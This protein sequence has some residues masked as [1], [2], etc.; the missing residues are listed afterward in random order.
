[1]KRSQVYWLCQVLGW[2]SHAAANVAF[3]VGYGTSPWRLIAIYTWGACAAIACTHG[4]RAWIRRT[5]WLRL[6]PL[7]VL[8]RVFFASLLIGCAITILIASLWPIVFSWK[9]LLDGHWSWVFPAIFVWSITA[10]LWAV[11]YF[12]VHYFESYE[13]SE[14]EKLRLA[15]VA[16]DAELRVLLSQVNPHFIFN[17]LNS[18]RALILEDAPRAQ[19]MV[20]EL[21]NML[22]YSLQSGRTE[23]VSLET[24]L[25]AVSAYLKLEAIRLEERLR[26]RID[27]DPTSLET[28]IPPMLLQTLV[29][30]G[31]KHGI[32]RLP[33]GG[34]IRVASHMR[35]GALRIEVRN[36]GQLAE[37][38]GTTRVGLENIRQRLRLL[39]G[40]AAS[41]V[42]RN[43]DA[44]FVV[45]EVSIPAVRANA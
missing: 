29:E 35:N 27:M 13:T 36:S 45:A 28:P 19:S 34:E 40:D 14:V 15:V 31:V 10:F 6:S 42:L 20:T 17:C 37:T 9:A 38:A 8:P 7:R 24:E 25:E 43:L 11:I 12:G 2:G 3:S 5:N 41:L 1:M 26:I 18:L 4:F 44:E 22:R 21:A 33:Q 39:Y 16:K 32:S 23:S 30:N